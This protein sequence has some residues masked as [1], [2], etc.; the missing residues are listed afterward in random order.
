MSCSVYCCSLLLPPEEARDAP[1][2]VDRSLPPGMYVGVGVSGLSSPVLDPSMVVDPSMDSRSTCCGGDRSGLSDP[3]SGKT[4]SCDGWGPSSGA[5]SG[6]RI[7]PEPGRAAGLPVGVISVACSPLPPLAV[8]VLEGVA[9]GLEGDG[10]RSDFHPV[11][12]DLHQ[13]ERC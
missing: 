10:S 3:K 11:S 4:S 1:V 5:P 7:L 8:V 2:V 9:D 6:G 12:V 13:F